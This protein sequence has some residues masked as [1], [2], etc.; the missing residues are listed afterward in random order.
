MS[1]QA[2]LHTPTNPTDH[3]G[4]CLAPVSNANSQQVTQ[5]FITLRHACCY[6][7][8]FTA[9]SPL[10]SINSLT[11]CGEQWVVI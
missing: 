7:P 8:S 6:L 5:S 3:T 2:Q 9:S 10:A 1:K 4:Q 11:L